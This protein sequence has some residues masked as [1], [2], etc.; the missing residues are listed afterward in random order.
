M[1][2][3]PWGVEVNLDED[4]VFS[5][6]KHAMRLM[7]YMNSFQTAITYEMMESK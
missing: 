3:F 6:V 2:A 4:T 1:D 5:P 7:P